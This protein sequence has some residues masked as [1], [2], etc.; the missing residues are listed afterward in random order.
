MGCA[1]LL[2]DGDN[3]ARNGGSSGGLVKGAK[4]SFKFQ[5]VCGQQ[6]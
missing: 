4:L 3:G 6:R 1:A 5:R 2:L